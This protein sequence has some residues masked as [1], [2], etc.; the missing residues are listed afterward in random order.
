M[1]ELWAWFNNSLV[2]SDIVSPLIGAI[3]GALFAGLNSTP[4]QGAPVSVNQTVIVFK[5]T[6]IVNQWRQN[7]NSSDDAIAYLFTV[8]VLAA[9]VMWGY[10]RYSE[11]ILRYWLNGLFSCTAFIFSAGLASSFHGHY[12]SSEWKWY[13]FAPIVVVIF[14][15]YLIHLAKSGT[16]PGAR[17]AAQSTNFF[18]FYIRVLKDNHRMWLLFQIAGLLLGVV[19]AFTA[20]IRSLYYLLIMNQRSGSGM[21]TLWSSMARLTMFSSG[22]TGTLIITVSIIISYFT[23]SGTAYEWWQLNA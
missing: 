14:S 5:E 3:L 18:N 6:V 19:S 15:F 8:F 12:S 22:R 20:T 4:A 2:Q 11:E 7:S 23:L 17:E 1:Q 9:A 16:I 21:A 13:I 10:S